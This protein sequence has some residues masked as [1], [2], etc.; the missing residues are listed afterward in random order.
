MDLGGA[1][2]CIA[3][4]AAQSK[5]SKYLQVSNKFDPRGLKNKLQTRKFF[6]LSMKPLCSILKLHL[7]FISYKIS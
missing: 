1:G 2:N 5:V 3:H 7:S 4:M 6:F